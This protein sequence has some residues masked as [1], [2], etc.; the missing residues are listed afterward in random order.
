MRTHLKFVAALLC[1]VTD[2][3]KY[4]ANV[5]KMKTKCTDFA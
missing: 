1:E 4:D 2:T 3:F 5:E